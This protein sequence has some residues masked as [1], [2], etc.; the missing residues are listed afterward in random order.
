V[1]AL[2]FVLMLVAAPSQAIIS[3]TA[4]A[5]SDWNFLVALGTKFRFTSDG[6]MN[7]AQYCGGSLIAP[8]LVLTAAHCVVNYDSGANSTSIEPAS[9]LVVGGGTVNLSAMTGSIDSVGGHVVSVVQLFV[10]PDYAVQLVATNGF[11]SSHDVAILELSATPNGAAV[12][13]VASTE[14]ITAAAD[15]GGLLAAVA[16]WGDRTP[17]ATGDYATIAESAAVTVISSTVCS[18]PSGQVTVSSPN[19]L[20]STTISG[21]NVSDVGAYEAA[22]MLCAAGISNTGALTDSCLGDSGGPLTIAGPNGVLLAGV[23]SW[24]PT[25]GN[26]LCASAQ[27]GIYARA[28]NLLEQGLMGNWPAAQPVVT[29][30]IGQLNISVTPTATN[31]GRWTFYVHQAIAAVGSCTATLDASTGTAHCAVTGLSSSQNYTVFGVSSLG[32]QSADSPAISP[33]V[34]VS[35]KIPS[36]VVIVKAKK[37]V[38]NSKYI[39]TVFTLTALANRS[40]I[41]SYAMTCKSGTLVVK[42]NSKTRVVTF[43]KLARRHT[44]MCSAV[45]TNGIGKSKTSKSFKVTT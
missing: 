5:N 38:L 44:W 42:A 13:D 15:S 20:Q 10:H 16:G 8:R 2:S 33:L 41:K 30:G 25:V 36:A 45:V 31:S 6:N 27:P 9:A 19:G 39:K 23:T 35:A 12:V 34:A 22:N 21:L 3:G 17:D 29:A 18:D 32:Q 26:L 4:I 1:G 24:G 40:A 37:T 43:T 14:E 11:A 7:S 28:S